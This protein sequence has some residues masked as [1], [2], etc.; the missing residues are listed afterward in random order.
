VIFSLSKAAICPTLLAALRG[1]HELWAMPLGRS[2]HL[3]VPP[4]LSTAATLQQ[5]TCTVTK[6]TRQS[7]SIARPCPSVSDAIVLRA[8]SMLKD[9]G[10]I[11]VG[12]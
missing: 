10:C 2:L 4:L 6:H 11:R 3:K 9:N 5:G 12:R 7:E 1:G 8:S